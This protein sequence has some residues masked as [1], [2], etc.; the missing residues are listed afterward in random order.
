[1]LKRSFLVLS[2][3]GL[4]FA[5]V[6]SQTAQT[7]AFVPVTDEMLANPSPN[8]WLMFSRTYDAQRYS[9]LK[10][11]TKDNVGQLKLVFS[12][13]MKTGTQE[14]IPIVYRGVI[15]A[16]TPGS[17]IQAIDG[18][19]GKLLWEY[20]RPTG[21][22][23]TKGI[24]IYQDMIYYTAPEGVIVALDA[25]DGKVRWEQ[26]IGEAQQT[27]GPIVVEGKVISGRAC[28]RTRESCFIAANDARTG[29]SVWKFQDIPAPGEPGSESWGPGGPA[30]NVM[31]S[32]WALMGSFD[33]IRRVIY[34]GIANPMPNTRMERHNGDPEGTAKTAPAD[35]YSNSTV[36][37]D[38]ATGKLKWY[39][40]HLPGD[41]WDQDYTNERVLF[42]TP[43]S[44][45]P[46]YVKW[47][48]PAIKKGEQHDVSVNVGEGGGIW[49]LDRNSGEFLW[50][51]PFPYDNPNFLISGIDV[52]TGRVTINYDL[53][54]KKPGDH[55]VICFW[56][57]KS[58]WPM[59]YNPVTNSLYVPFNDNCLDMTA[60]DGTKNERR[61]GSMGPRAMADPSFF[62][63][64]E[65]VNMTTG[66]ITNLFHTK[67]PS[68]G[69]TL[70][71]AGGLVFWGDLDRN[72]YAFDAETGKM[73]WQTQIDAPIQNSTITYAVNGK[74]YIAV[75]G[76][77]GGLSSGLLRQAGFQPVQ[78]DGLYV[79]SLP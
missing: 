25:R 17:A 13:E 75:L 67:A 8:D 52:K 31:A 20:K 78:K 1:M 76:G 32:T 35:L 49:A 22:S 26:K 65:K 9:P 4:M 42:R 62:G 47:I 63:G 24:A 30:D 6:A 64:I 55:H 46:Q 38:P 41:D 3:L 61:V 5:A 60:K 68:N 59:S 36:A 40:Q 72:F 50:S 29:E 14:S 56:N 7:P 77:L 58:Y 37:L 44:P 27:S 11:I 69:A 53:V 45:D 51:N 15:Y 70:S 54:M 28:A 71:T 39:Y 57:T 48:N 16:A 12:T 34:W 21:M 19:N 18:T 10:Q 66:Q 73:L 79:F 23:K 74:Q 43:V 2:V 33:P